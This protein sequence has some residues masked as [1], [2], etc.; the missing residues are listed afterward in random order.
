MRLQGPGANKGLIL[1]A[2]ILIL[3]VAAALA[4]FLLIAPR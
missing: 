3:I 1:I 2:I 4:Y